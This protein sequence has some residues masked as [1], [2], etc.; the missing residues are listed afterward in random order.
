MQSNMESDSIFND[1]GDISEQKETGRYWK[2]I[3]ADDDEQV[4]SSTKIVLSDLIFEDKKINFLSAYSSRELKD[5]LINNPDT[6]V[7]LLDVVMESYSAGLDIVKVIRE[8][9]KN[10]N[11]RIILRTGQPGHAP[12]KKVIMDY[13]INDYREKNELTSQKLFTAVYSALKA[14][15]DI[16]SINSSREALQYILDASENFIKVR[17]AENLAEKS[18][19]F[20]YKLSTLIDSDNIAENSFSAL[21]D[22]DK[23]E[24]LSKKGN[25]SFI[26][27]ISD[28]CPEIQEK[29]RSIRNT[30]KDFFQDSNSSYLMSPAQF[31][32]HLIYL[33]DF[34]PSSVDEKQ[35]LTLFNK[36]IGIAFENLFLNNEIINTQI[37]LIHVLGEIIENR[38][39]ETAY[40]VTRV[41]KITEIMMKT[42]NYKDN[43]IEIYSHASPLHDVGKIG[44]SDSILL[45]PGKLDDEEFNKIKTHTT[46]GYKLLSGSA[47]ELLKTAAVIA[48]QHHEKWNGKGYPE[49]L[50]GNEINRATRIISIADVYDALS[51]DRVY[52]KAWET[53]KI[54]QYIEDEKEKSFDPEL[55][56]CFFD[57]SEEII[58]LNTIYK[59]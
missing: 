45:K 26:K 50:K 6:A 23:V 54:L 30:N 15:K 55:V 3:I 18:L 7:I 16:R 56:E 40:H 17:S 29:I 49:G 22:R 37:E 8:E 10:K 41:S 36:K 1:S 34:I 57:N 4:H 27:N 28:C 2:V 44:I 52:K 11:I 43:E 42:L 13:D 24:I 5:V 38:S 9:L 39:H 59:D 20:V 46:I 21:I 47:K 53:G 14:Y 48:L 33:K 32:K 19:D 51:N 35:I 12:E 31:K 25:L 58:A